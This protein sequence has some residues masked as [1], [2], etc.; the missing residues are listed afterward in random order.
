MRILQL[1]VYGNF[2]CSRI[3]ILSTTELFQCF[4]PIP[5]NFSSS[6]YFLI[7]SFKYPSFYDPFVVNWDLFWEKYWFTSLLSSFLWWLSAL[8][9]SQ[10]FLYCIHYLTSSSCSHFENRKVLPTMTTYFAKIFYREVNPLALW[11]MQAI[12]CDVINY[13]EFSVSI[14]TCKGLLW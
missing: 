12:S 10:A 1:H 11:P 14:E 6:K 9:S 4:K 8:S 3:I 13:I 5:V 7:D 2:F